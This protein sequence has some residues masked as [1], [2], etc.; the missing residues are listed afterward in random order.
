MKIILATVIGAILGASILW[1][2]IEA[3]DDHSTSTSQKVVSE[4]PVTSVLTEDIVTV[5]IPR[6]QVAAGQVTADQTI[7]LG[8]RI[9]GY[10]SRILPAE[11]ATVEVGELLIEIDAAS[12]ESAIRQAKASLEE[13]RSEL[14]DSSADVKRFTDLA[15]THAISKERL[16][17]EKLRTTRAKSAVDS[18]R[19][20]LAEQRAEL[21]YTR[22]KS[23]VRARVIEHLSKSGDLAVPGV[24]IMRIESLN[25]SHFETWVPI[26]I[27]DQL[28]IG[29]N[30][31][32][33]LDGQNEPVHS[34]ITELVRS[35]DPMTRRC[36][37]RLSLPKGISTLV[38][39][40]GHA[41]FLIG[42]DQRPVISEQAL[43][44][45]AGIEGVFVIDQGGLA[46]FRSVRTGR[47]W[48][49]KVE[50]L[51]S[52]PVGQTVILAPQMNLRDGDPVKGRLNP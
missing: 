51:A 29:E 20:K 19:A 40:Y 28:S 7:E 18:A 3:Q 30:V 4:R 23:P 13:A 5:D 25:A 15:K 17:K 2:F 8:S 41:N 36:K 48:N 24:P 14:S 45:R 1:F 12:V 47:R 26:S 32:L 39:H 37:V 22:I 9:S 33:S 34:V 52:P 31:T 38:G 21:A 46:R 6:L 44:K 10:I 16:R 50:L 35:A 43:T 42:S 27:I 11:G 49:N